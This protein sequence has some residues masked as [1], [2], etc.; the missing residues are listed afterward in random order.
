VGLS[1]FCNSVLSERAAGRRGS[2][3]SILT[4]RL[5][6]SPKCFGIRSRTIAR[7]L[8]TPPEHRPHRKIEVAAVD[9]AKIG[10][11]TL[12]DRC[13]LVTMRLS[14]ARRKISVKR[15]T[16]TAPEATISA[17]TCLGPTDSS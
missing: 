14:G 5:G 15:T 12:G 11:L 8:R 17:S 6:S 10:H 4:S 9:R 7:S 1:A 13:A 2:A 16:E 3:Q